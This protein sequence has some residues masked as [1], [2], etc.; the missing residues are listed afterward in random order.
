[1]PAQRRIHTVAFIPYDNNSV[2]SVAHNTLSPYI[3]RG[4]IPKNLH[5]RLSICRRAFLYFS[6]NS[7]TPGST[8]LK[9][10]HNPSRYLSERLTCLS[11]KQLETGAAPRAYMAE[12]IFGPVLRS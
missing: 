5:Y 4:I 6:L 7:D 3:F 10:Q 1:M 8:F 11:L 9:R 12:A 2:D